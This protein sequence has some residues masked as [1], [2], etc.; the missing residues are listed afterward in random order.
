MNHFIDAF[1]N[2]DIIYKTFPLL[3]RGFKITLLLSIIVVPTGLI[4]GLVVALM[5][6]SS[7]S[8]TRVAAIIWTDLFRALPPLVLLIFLYTG[9]PFAGWMISPWAAVA[10]GFFMNT[11]AY[12]GEIFRSGI[13]SVARGQM[14]AA[15]STGLTKPQAFLYVVLPQAVRNVAPDLISN[16][17]EIVKYTSLASVVALEEL[18]FQA[19][20]A[21]ALTYNASPIVAAA[22]MYLVVL[23]PFVRLVSRLERKAIVHSR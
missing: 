6:S 5:A 12:Y 16:T 19:R 17:L 7:S 8:A 14:E 11:S 20:Q 18:L 4:G 1:L 21:Q 13:D 22:L 3:W 9:L 15:R 23:W 10:I 2:V